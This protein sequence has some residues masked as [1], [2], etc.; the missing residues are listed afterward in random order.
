MDRTRDSES[1][2]GEAEALDPYGMNRRMIPGIAGVA[3]GAVQSPVSVRFF[4][5]PESFTVDITPVGMMGLVSERI[6]GWST[7]WYELLP[8]KES[9]TWKG[10]R[11][12]L[13]TSDHLQKKSRKHRRGGRRT[14]SNRKK[15]REESNGGKETD[16]NGS[17]EVV[18]EKRLVEEEATTVGGRLASGTT[19]DRASLSS[20]YPAGPAQGLEERRKALREEAPE[21]L[22]MAKDDLGLRGTQC[23]TLLA[24]MKFRKRQVSIKASSVC[25]EDP[26]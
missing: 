20:A 22:E 4:H 11:G 7:A 14:R 21:S 23:S 1:E 15:C 2:G 5:S 13:K 24:F 17:N 19:E 6:S 8:L 26:V 25:P 16:R 10:L 3:Q 9:R 12:N 18:D